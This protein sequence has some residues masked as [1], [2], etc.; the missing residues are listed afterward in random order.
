MSGQDLLGI[1]LLKKVRDEEMA[2]FVGVSLDVY[3]AWVDPNDEAEPPIKVVARVAKT[4]QGK[5]FHSLEDEEKVAAREKMYRQCELLG[6]M[7]EQELD[8]VPDELMP[9]HNEKQ[10]IVQRLMSGLLNL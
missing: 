3:Q 7:L 6:S 10:S 5:T 9:L 2:V 4:I 1:Q 8:M